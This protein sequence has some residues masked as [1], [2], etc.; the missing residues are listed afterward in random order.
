M[1][2]RLRLCAHTDVQNLFIFLHEKPAPCLDS[3]ILGRILKGK[4]AVLRIRIRIRI[5]IRRIQMFF[6][7]VD[8]GSIGQK[9]LDSTVLWLLF[10]ILSSKND[11]NVPS[12][13]I[14]RKTCFLLASWRSMTKIAGSWSE[15]ESGFISQRHGFA[16]P[17]PQQNVMDPQPWKAEWKTSS[18]SQMWIFHNIGRYLYCV[19]ICEMC[20]SERLKNWTSKYISSSQKVKTKVILNIKCTWKVRI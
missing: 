20:S 4:A 7:L 19:V 11:V 17:D 8:Y 16:D 14:S 1:V 18:E 15:S 12:K 6:S 13:S 2:P 3:Y 9:N 5:R 10:D